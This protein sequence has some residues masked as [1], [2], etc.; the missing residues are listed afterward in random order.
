MTAPVRV[1]FLGAGFIAR[2]HLGLLADA[3]VDHHTVA[4]FDPDDG[5]ARSFADKCGAEVCSSADDVLDQVDAVYVCTWTSEHR[6]LVEQAAQRGVAVFC[7]KPVA[8]TLDDATQMVRAVEKAGVVNQVGLILRALPS[9]RRLR[10][11]LADPENGRAMTFVFRDDQFLPVRG[12]YE[13]TWRADPAK[14]GSGALLEHSIHDLD[15]LEWL[16]GPVVAVSAHTAEF[17]GISG[18]ED[19]AVVM[20]ELES[21]A[22][23]TLTSV[24]HEVTARP[25]LRRLEVF[26][27]RAW[28]VLEGDF[29]GPIVWQRENGEDGAL[30]ADELWKPSDR[31]DLGWSNPAEAFLLAMRDGT[32]ASPSF[33]DALR[34]HVL[35]AGVYES[36]AA[37]SR[38]SV[39]P[40]AEG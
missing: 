6:Y 26:C 18:I 17:H 11:L 13:S 7:E 29:V 33:R 35:A 14:A 15:I 8:T 21:G 32:P 5:R 34:A 37:G 4:V 30:N 9:F 28:L 12:H 24:W 39:D 36:A 38:V 20:L 23:G 2:F 19:L 22:V 27:E 31:E 3:D 25:S 10:D 1:G 40:V 16:L